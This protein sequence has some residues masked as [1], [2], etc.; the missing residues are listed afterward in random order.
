MAVSGAVREGCGG[1]GMVRVSCYSY[2]YKYTCT[3][4]SRAV[5][6]ERGGHMSQALRSA[7]GLAF[8]RYCHC[9]YCVLY[10]LQ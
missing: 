9:Q 8:T 5:A 10:I 3:C 6:V 1:L 2:S 4:S 7:C